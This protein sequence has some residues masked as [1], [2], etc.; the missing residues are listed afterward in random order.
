M[1]RTTSRRIG[2]SLIVLLAAC[3]FVLLL[4]YVTPLVY[5]FII[6]WLLAYAINPIVNM[7]HAKLKLPRWIGV[8]LTLLLFVAAMLTIVSALVTRIVV[9]IIHLSK[10][11]NTTIDWWRNEFERLVARPEIQDL[12]DKLSTFYKENPNYQDTI[13][14]RISDT[15]N[16]VASKSSDLITTILNTIVALISSLPNVA[17]ILVVVLLAAFFISKDWQRH[18]VKVSSWFPEP[19]LKSTSAVWNDLQKALF[20]YFRAQFI[21]ISIT[22]CVVTIGLLILRVDYAISIGLLIGLVDLLPYLGV[23]A[24]MIPWIAYTFI[25]GDI[26]LGIGLSVLYGVILI[27]RQML[28]PKVLASSVGLDPLPTL[29]A[30]FVGLKLFGV[31][32]LI[33]GPVSLVILSAIHKANVFRDLYRYVI[34][35]AK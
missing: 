5:P 1:D 30:M 3:V 10:S 8:T 18:S 19:I 4:I 34:R 2:R 13:N 12:I 16:L 22:A 25:Y 23:G 35:G 32:G 33:I 7:L 26:S 21:M 17:T 6:G 31:F 27:A 29:I 11:L 15:A 24:A 28:E 9:E 20:G 14:S